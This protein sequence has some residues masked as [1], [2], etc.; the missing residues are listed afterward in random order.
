M[1]GDQIDKVWFSQQLKRKG[2]SQ[3]DLARFLNLD[4]SAVTRMLNGER[5]MSVEEQ[6]RIAEYLDVPVGDV[7]LHR[8]GAAAGFSESG[9][10][11]YSGLAPFGRL[12]READN[13]GAA[14]SRHPI[15]G[16]MKGTITVMPDV[17]LTEP[18]DFEWGEKLY[19]E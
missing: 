18:V 5:N 6:D 2:R 9:Q 13:A 19:N 15:F 10:A 7:A 17:D 12:G 11:P 1:I 3:A 8:R 14:E 4:R 16:C